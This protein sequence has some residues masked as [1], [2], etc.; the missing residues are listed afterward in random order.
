MP[1]Q[2][3][4]CGS[5]NADNVSFC[6]NCGTPFTTSQPVAQYPATPATPQKVCV[7]CHRPIDV[8]YASCPY[9]GAMQT[10]AQ[11]PQ[12]GFVTPPGS[13]SKVTAGLLALFLGGLGVHK[14]YLGQTGLGILY[15]LF[16][17]TGVPSII[18]LIEGIIYFSTSDLDFYQKYH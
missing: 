4:K 11:Y 9:C 17:W 15:L 6:S 12:A 1:L 14:F 5:M 8:N 16:C 13:K 3:P 10:A 7:N 18:A 2:C